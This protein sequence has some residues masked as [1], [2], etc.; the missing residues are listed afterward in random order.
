[1]WQ[2]ELGIC[3]DAFLRECH[4]KIND[5]QIKAIIVDLHCNC[6][7]L[8]YQQPPDNMFTY[9]LPVRGRRKQLPS[10]HGIDVAPVELN[11]TDRTYP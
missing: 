6:V 1:V 7:K 8:S 9:S 2:P 4:L 3:H 5:K 11:V 10:A